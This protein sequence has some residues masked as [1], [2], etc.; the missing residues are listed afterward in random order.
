MV[1]QKVIHW[2]QLKGSA[3]QGFVPCSSLSHQLALWG[4]EKTIFSSWSLVSMMEELDEMVSMSLSPY[5]SV[6]I[7]G[8]NCIG[9]EF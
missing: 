9:F 7:L 3:F 8:P 6:I 4:S 2:I 5:N 1:E